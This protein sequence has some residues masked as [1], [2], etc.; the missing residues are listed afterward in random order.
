[1]TATG[2]FVAAIS[3]ALDFFFLSFFT[4]GDLDRL[5][6]V[7]SFFDRFAEGAVSV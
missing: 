3:A 5:S 7:F 2:F 4:F 1:M 6:F